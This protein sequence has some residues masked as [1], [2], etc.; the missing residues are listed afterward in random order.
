MHE[1][2]FTRRVGELSV[3][4][5]LHQTTDGR[6]VDDARRITGRDVA[7]FRQQRQERGRHEELGRDVGLEGVLPVGDFRPEHVLRD[8]FRRFH[9]RFPILGE[10][11]VAVSGDACVV[12]EQM[13]ALGLLLA[14]RVGESDTFFLLGDVPR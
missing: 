12:D 1:A 9:V 4:R 6:D 5:A 10:F 2:G 13:D 3:A 14:H 11:G 7:P 8:A